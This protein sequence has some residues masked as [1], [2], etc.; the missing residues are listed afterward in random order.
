MPPSFYRDC[1]IKQRRNWIASLT[2]VITALMP[3]EAIAVSS[4][5]KFFPAARSGWRSLLQPFVQPTERALADVSFSVAPGEAVA[6]MALTEQASLRYF[7]S[8][9]PLFFPRAVGPLSLLMT[10]NARL[11]RPAANSA[12]IP[13]VT[14]ASTAA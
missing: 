7:A 12:T 11:L 8:W 3:A 13:E 6:I 5:E 14:K 10:S 2:S 4:L 9:L 1:T